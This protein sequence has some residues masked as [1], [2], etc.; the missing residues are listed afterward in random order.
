MKILKILAII[1]EWKKS[2]LH[3]QTVEEKNNR[4]GNN[5]I[6]NSKG[7]PKWKAQGKERHIIAI[8]LKTI[9][10]KKVENSQRG[11]IYLTFKGTEIR[12]IVDL[13]MEIMK[14]R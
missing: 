9:K 2:I 4:T 14:G 6:N 1:Y 13:S 7:F 10:E 12:I 8:L 5:W 3:V 11:K